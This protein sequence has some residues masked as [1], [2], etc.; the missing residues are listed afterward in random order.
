M[1]YFG[2]IRFELSKNFLL[3]IKLQCALKLDTYFHVLSNNIDKLFTFAPTYKDINGNLDLVLMLVRYILN[4]NI[5]IFD[6]FS[7]LPSHYYINV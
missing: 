2:S 5:F 7:V 6:I 3:Y 4:Q 1:S